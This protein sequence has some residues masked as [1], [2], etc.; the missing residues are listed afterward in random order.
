VVSWRTPSSAKAQGIAGLTWLTT[1]FVVS[2]FRVFQLNIARPMRRCS[3]SSTILWV[4]CHLACM[5][6]SLLFAKSSSAQNTVPVTDPDDSQLWTGVQF[7]LTLREQTQLILSGS[8]RQGRDFSHPVYETGG[9]AVRFRLGRY[10]ALSP[11]YQFIATQYYPGVH[12]RENRLSI[13]GVVSIPIKW[14]VID[15]MHQFEQRFRELQNSNRYRSRVQVEWPFRLRDGDYRLFCWEEAYYDWVP[16]AWSRNR[17]A[18]GGGKRLKPNLAID[19]FFLKQN[20][21]F[22]RPRDINAIGVTFRI[23]LDRPVHHLP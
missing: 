6:L 1:N 2:L 20:A 22:S 13:N 3:T 7:A 12:T 9:A 4:Q 14:L 23:Q 19:L 5:L 16:H 8:F 18:V 17:F 11:I 10:F 21:R 15:N